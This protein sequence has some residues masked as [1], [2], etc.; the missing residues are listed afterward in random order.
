MKSVLGWEL[1]KALAY[2]SEQGIRPLVQE[3][4]S[5]RGVDQ[6]EERVVRLR[7][8][9]AGQYVLTWTRFQTELEEQQKKNTM[10]EVQ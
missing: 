1:N 9:G 6:G 3:T 10:S 2:L 5:R 8:D 7:Q 4:R